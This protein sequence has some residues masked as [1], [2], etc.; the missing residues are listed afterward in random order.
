ML[1]NK[2]TKEA[3]TMLKYS[4]FILFSGFL[5]SLLHRVIKLLMKEK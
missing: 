1:N 2:I 5:Y 4:M 3:I